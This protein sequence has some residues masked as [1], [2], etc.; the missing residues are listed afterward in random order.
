MISK[1]REPA[2]APRTSGENLPELADSAGAEPVPL[3]ES[4]TPESQP[5]QDDPRR[6]E[7]T[8][9]DHPG[10]GSPAVRR[11]HLVLRLTP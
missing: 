4:C 2:V 11:G 1:G 5:A 9:K 3:R 6:H 7:A 8:A 10:R